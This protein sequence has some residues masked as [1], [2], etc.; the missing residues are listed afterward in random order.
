MQEGNTLK[1][2]GT[3]KQAP[4]GRDERRDRDLKM[5][6]RSAVPEWAWICPGWEPPALRADVRTP[7]L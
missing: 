7:A 3:S 5:G 2:V 1:T 6:D 4:G